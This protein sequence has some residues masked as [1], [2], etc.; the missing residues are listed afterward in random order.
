MTDV[1][2]QMT[3]E[4]IEDDEATL[5]EP[6]LYVDLEAVRRMWMKAMKERCPI[7]VSARYATW[8]AGMI[9][10]VDKQQGIR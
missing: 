10:L 8:V 4:K 1:L 3:I 6:D 5:P 2:T 7:E 9:M